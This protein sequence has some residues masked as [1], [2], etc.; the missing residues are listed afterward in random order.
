MK[1]VHVSDIPGATSLPGPLGYQ[2]FL[3]TKKKTGST[4]FVFGFF[5]GKLILVKILK[6][7]VQMCLSHALLHVLPSFPVF[8]WTSIWELKYIYIYVY[9]YM[10]HNSEVSCKVKNCL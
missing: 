6:G 10:Y 7:E 8:G 1:I 5:F 9:I 2:K 4:S 3:V